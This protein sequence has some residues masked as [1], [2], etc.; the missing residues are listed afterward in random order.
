MDDDIIPRIKFIGRIQK[1][2]NVNVKH[3]N[4]QQVSLLMK[5]IRSFIHNDTRAN[6]F[7]F[8]NNTIKKGFE[9]LSLHLGVDKD[10]DRSLCQNLTNDLKQCKI[11]MLNIRETYIED[12]M[13]CC[14]ID[15]LIEETDARL[16]DIEV[17]YEFLKRPFDQL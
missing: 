6:T 3:M 11:G 16:H 15:A 1:G 10:Y 7:T 17:K 14:K 2:E 9:I 8:I 12:L 5:L 13:F 4:I